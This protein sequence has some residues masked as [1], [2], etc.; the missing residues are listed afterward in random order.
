[1]YLLDTNVTGRGRPADIRSLAHAPPLAPPSREKVRNHPKVLIRRPAPSPRRAPCRNPPPP[2]TERQGPCPMPGQADLSRFFRDAADRSPDVA[3][4]GAARPPETHAWTS[5]RH[6]GA[7]RPGAPAPE[8]IM[9]MARPAPPSSPAGA[10]SAAT[11]TVRGGV[12]ASVSPPQC[13]QRS[14]QTRLHHRQEIPVREQ[15]RQASSIR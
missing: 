5:P 12:P 15:Q 2:F 13:W 1:M 9:A 10:V 6:R 11:A 3:H 8:R 4:P 7:R 14:L